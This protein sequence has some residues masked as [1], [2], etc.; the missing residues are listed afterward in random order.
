MELLLMPRADAAFLATDACWQSAS[1]A[2]A[3]RLRSPQS[4]APLIGRR[5][6]GNSESCAPLVAATAAVC[7]A[8]ATSRRRHSLQGTCS[9][10]VCCGG[11]SACS[12]PTRI[13]RRG[14]SAQ[15]V[16]APAAPSA[17]PLAK[18][19]RAFGHLVGRLFQRKAED[20]YAD[21]RATLP[22]LIDTPELT[23]DSEARLEEL[24]AAFQTAYGSFRMTGEEREEEFRRYFQPAQSNPSYGEVDQHG[25]ARILCG[26]ELS[27]EN[28]FV[29]VGSGLGKLVVLSSRLTD[30]GTAWGDLSELRSRRMRHSAS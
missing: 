18:L 3:C 7:V 8:A 24:L 15:A 27:A 11:G 9:A 2:A 1:Q 16:A 22:P 19:R 13:A 12:R 26:A 21:A 14:R 17:T 29:D 25:V 20:A 6:V 30:V 23:A 10:L 4:S 5:S 28:G